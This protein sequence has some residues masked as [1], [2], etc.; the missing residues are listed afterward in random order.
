[1]V[2]A[3]TFLN[4][5][6]VITICIGVVA[7]AVAGGQTKATDKVPPFDPAY[8]VGTWAFDWTIPETPLGPAGDMAGTE[9][10][11]LMPSADVSKRVNG[12]PGFPDEVARKI[13]AHASLVLESR[14]E[15]T[16]PAG[17]IRSRTVLIY[18]RNTDEATQYAVDSSGSVSVRHGTLTGDLGG[19]YTFTWQSTIPRDGREIHLKGR[20]VAFSPLNYRD[21]VQYSLDNKR[22]VTYGQPWYRKQNEF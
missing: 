3:T 8:F 10:F 1:M 7:P 12:F 21:F 19:I 14:I 4:G 13:N 17:V 11:R 5:L 20:R 9:T 22:F 16:G 18:D 2:G 6:A 15:G